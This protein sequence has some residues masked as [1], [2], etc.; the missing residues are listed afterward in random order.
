MKWIKIHNPKTLNSK[1]RTTY[2]TNDDLV[3][4]IKRA[5]K[6][7]RA[8]YRELYYVFEGNWT[9]ESIAIQVKQ[10]NV[11]LRNGRY[12]SNHGNQQEFDFDTLNIGEDKQ[13]DGWVVIE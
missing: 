13:N 8:K 1:H 7:F 10:F 5:S 3:T 12:G 9:R 6:L 4:A 2:V 11:L